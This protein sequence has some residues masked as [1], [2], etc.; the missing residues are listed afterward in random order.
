[1]AFNG[2]YVSVKTVIENVLRD[3][4]YYNEISY[5]DVI[6]WTARAIDLIG[7]QL[8]YDEKFTVLSV[9]D[10]RATLPVDLMELLA[11]RDNVTKA[12]F[13]ASTDEFAGNY[14]TNDEDTYASDD[15]RPLFGSYRVTSGYLFTNYEQGDI[16]IKYL[17]Y[18]LCDDSYPMIP[19][20]TRYLMGIEAYLTFKIDNKLWRRGKISKAIRDVSEQEWLWYVNSAFTKMVTPDYDKAESLKNQWLKIRGDEAAHDYSFGG[21]NLP[22]VKRVYNADVTK[23]IPRT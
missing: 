13:I 19:D 21:L 10:Y 23:R 20:V 9:V 3:T 12:P 1:M 5:H 11:V 16:E 22:T 15:N 14:A 7:V 4:D 8:A 18:R 6:E 2:K 17:A